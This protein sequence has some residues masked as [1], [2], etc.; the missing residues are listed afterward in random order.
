MKVERLTLESVVARLVLLGV[1]TAGIAF[2]LLVWPTRTCS[3]SL[4]N[5]FVVLSP[6]WL[7]WQEWDEAAVKRYTF[8]G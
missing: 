1:L 8:G 2:V 5:P 4:I 3:P 6:V 7:E